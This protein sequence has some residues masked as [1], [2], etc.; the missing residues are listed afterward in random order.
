MKKLLS[1]FLEF[2]R[3]RICIFVTC[4]GIIGYLLFNTISMNLVFVVLAS[5]LVTA[6]AYSFNNITDKKEDLINR[7]KI[8]PFLINKSGYLISAICFSFGMFFSFFLSVY[9]IVFC[10]LGLFVSITYSFFRLKERFLVKNLY[11]GFGASV[12]FL[13]GASCIS[14]EIFLYYLIFSLFI[15][16]GSTISDLRDY[17]GDRLSNIKTLPVYLG[18]EVCKKIDFVLLSIFSVV[19]LFFS[20]FIILLPFSIV[21]F[22]FLYK[23]KPSL[24]H[25]CE[26]FSFI[27]LVL[28][29]VI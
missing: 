25:S 11:T 6:G 23:N 7:K 21:M 1:D 28:W 4:I 8:N 10:S 14:L 9:S 24:A 26:G 19:I 29:S 18:Y 15:F 20:H 5:F 3:F 27:F 16:I 2:I 17:E 13:A 22:Y 12:V